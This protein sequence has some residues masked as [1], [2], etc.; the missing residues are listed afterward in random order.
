MQ[1]IEVK[2]KKSRRLF[3]R[4]PHRVYRDQ[5]HWI[6]PLEKDINELLSPKKNPFFTHGEGRRYVLLDKHGQPAGRIAA[7]IDFDLEEKV[8]YRSGGIGFFEC[9]PKEEYAFALF[10]KA[11]EYLK[12]F[13]LQAIDGPIS[14]G[15]RDKFWGLLV[16]GFDPPL[17]QEN[18]HP[19]YY[20]AFFEAWGFEPF[21]QILT[22][23]GDIDEVPIDR[24]SAIAERARRRYSF[25]AVHPD[26]K[27][28]EKYARDFAHIYNASFE[29]SPYFKPLE[30]SKVLRMFQEA[31]PIID[32]KVVSFAYCE[33]QPVG[34]CILLPEVNPFFKTMKGRMNLLNSLRFLY[35]FKTA[36]TKD[37]KGVAFGIHPDFHRK[38]L[39][40]LMV[41]KI[42]N[43]PGFTERYRHFYLAT[44]RSFNEIMVKS[45]MN[46]GVQIDR[47]HYTYRKV[48][49]PN[50]SYQPYEFIP[51]P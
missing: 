38:G 14:P 44:I 21:E 50:F 39:Y 20:K 11:E 18:Y 9:V 46:L 37:L 33:D 45:T 42:Y 30:V 40:S 2:D 29:H 32:P 17:Y 19:P 27:N 26:L 34:F 36:K 12:S 13:D 3:H 28:L 7:F 6:C 35:Q 5:P 47:V 43:N 24:F 51:E 23:R 22:F 48:L 1:I 31:R 15:E 16:N 49:D 8:G 4:V 25:T 41:A 10:A